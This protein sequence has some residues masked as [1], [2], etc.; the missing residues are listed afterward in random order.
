[1]LRRLPGEEPLVAAGILPEPMATLCQRWLDALA[2]LFEQLGLDF[3]FERLEERWVPAFGPGGGAEPE[4]GEAAPDG[5]PAGRGGRRGDDF[6]W[7]WGEFTLVARSDP[8][9][10]W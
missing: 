10:T 8:G 3:P 1:V 5:W 6:R 2:P 9:A 4:G 7:L